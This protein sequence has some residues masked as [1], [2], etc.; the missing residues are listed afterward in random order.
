[1]EIIQEKFLY[2]LTNPQKSILISEQFYVNKNMF[3]VASSAIIKEDIDFDALQKAINIFV[4]NNDAYRTR[5][6]KIADETY[7]YFEN[8]VPF[9]VEKIK[10]NNLDELEDY[11][12]GITFDIYSS[13]PIKFLMFENLTGYSGYCCVLHHLIGDAYTLALFLEESLK[14]YNQLSRTG[15]T[16]NERSSSYKD[17]IFSEENYLNSEKYLKDKAYW[18]DKFSTPSEIFSFKSNENIFDTLAARKSF[19]IPNHITAYCTENKIS[20]F[21][22]FFAAFSIYLS[23]LTNNEEVIIGTPFLNRLNHKE[24]NTAGMFVSVLPF[25]QTINPNLS[26]AEYV[27]E[28]SITQIRYAQTSKILLF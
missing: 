25:K 9:D 23:R 17:F 2:D 20:K 1:M 24:K 22:F 3:V 6:I 11:L 16:S 10:I 19:H 13:S 7:Q 4:Q 15:E 14:L 21:S 18:E 27:K 12:R 28:I 5:F 26:V 8:Y